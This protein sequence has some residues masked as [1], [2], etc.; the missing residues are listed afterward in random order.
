MNYLTFLEIIDYDIRSI[1]NTGSGFRTVNYINKD[2]TVTAFVIYNVSDYS[3]KI[4]SLTSSEKSVWYGYEKNVLV[5]SKG[6]TLEEFENIFRK[7][8]NKELPKKED[9]EFELDLPDEDIFE[10]MKIAHQQDITFNQLIEN[11]L[12]EYIKN[13]SPMP[14]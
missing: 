10:L 7:L 6:C 13:G 4:A 5:D 9:F 12:T 3:I 14:D 1:L 2:R 11:V 8:L